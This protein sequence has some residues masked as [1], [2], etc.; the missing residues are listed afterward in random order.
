M[1]IVRVAGF[2]L[3]S[4]CN[5]R[6]C[7]RSGEIYHECS[8]TGTTTNGRASY[9][10]Y[11]TMRCSLCLLFI[12]RSLSQCGKRE[13][14]KPCRTAVFLN[15]F[16]AKLSADFSRIVV[17]NFLKQIRVFSVLILRKVAKPCTLFKS[18]III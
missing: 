9:Y 17:L 18:Y 15:R 8:R 7:L 10:I 11:N 12:C 6:L 3:L 2:F 1:S 16:L 14:V 4:R 5:M 13:S